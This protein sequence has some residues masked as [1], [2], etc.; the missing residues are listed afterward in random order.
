MA[1]K[2]A[3]KRI[4]R[5]FID[6]HAMIG[7]GLAQRVAVMFGPQRREDGQRKTSAA[8]FLPEVFEAVAGFVAR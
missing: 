8:K 7:K 2:P 3:E 5:S 1:F 4:E 6:L